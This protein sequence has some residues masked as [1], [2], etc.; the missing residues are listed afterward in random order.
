MTGEPEMLV[1]LRG[2]LARVTLNRPKA[3]NALTPEMCRELDARLAAWAED[4]A[5]AAVL[6][7]GTGERAF[8][9]GGDVVTIYESARGDGK[10][11]AA[12]FRDEYRM[13]RRI[14]H[15][16]K[17]YIAV[18]DGITMGGGV[19]VSVHGSHRVATERTLFAMPETGIGLFPDV[20]STF[21]L[22]R[23]PG[24]PGLYLGLYLGLTGQRLQGADCLYCG[25]ATHYLERA[26]LAELER[27]LEQADW[28]GDPKATAGGLLDTLASEP[29]PPPLA[30]H[31]AAIDRCFAQDSVEAIL[32]A[33]EA[34]GGDWAETT[35][36]HLLTRSPTSLK[37]AFRQ[38]REGA[39]LDFDQAMI[40]EYRLASACVAGHDFPEG[41]R[42]AVIDKDRRPAW[43][44]AT[45][46]EV[47]DALVDRHFM[48]PGEGDLTFA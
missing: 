33:L 9:A 3:L 43:R 30:A 35:R 7:Q 21:F 39:A 38:L 37:V 1:E 45:L 22:P 12:F 20:G 42:A 31:R 8:C 41:V 25:I 5:V 24:A 46:A 4:P 2:A 15:F 40:M 13:N 6:I 16:P 14:F 47:G 29:G 17:P 19:G 28:S 48:P 32:D 23:L 26:R 18:I 11:A 27:A 36:A 34:E 44:P 10:L